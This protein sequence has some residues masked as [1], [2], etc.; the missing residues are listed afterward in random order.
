[1]KEASQWQLGSPV[2]QLILSGE[3]VKHMM[4]IQAG[5]KEIE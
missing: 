5:D 1:M 2:K 4:E 3:W